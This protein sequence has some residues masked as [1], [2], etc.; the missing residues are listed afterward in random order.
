MAARLGE[1]IYWFGCGIAILLIGGPPAMIFYNWTNNNLGQ[2]DSVGLS[3]IF[4]CGIIAWL[5]GRA[6]K[7]VLAGK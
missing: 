1:V 7:Y 4:A 2:V 3:I 5:V 6:A